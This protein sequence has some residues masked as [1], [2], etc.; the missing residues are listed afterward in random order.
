MMIANGIAFFAGVQICVVAIGNNVEL[1]VLNDIATKYGLRKRPCVG[2]MR[3]WR[4]F[5][6]VMKRAFILLR[7]E[8][9]AGKGD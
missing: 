4:Q 1:S 2:W 5:Y 8:K 3:S 9:K 7:K 6:S